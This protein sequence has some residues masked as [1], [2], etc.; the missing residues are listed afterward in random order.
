MSEA[1]NKAVCRRHYEEVLTNKR[2]DA[3]D[4]IHADQV[5]YGDSQSAPREQFKMLAL[6][7]SGRRST[8]SVCRGSWESPSPRG[9][10]VRPRDTSAPGR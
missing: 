8:S 1:K 9:A 4:E 10:A 6:A 2:L 5:A 3:I 7:S